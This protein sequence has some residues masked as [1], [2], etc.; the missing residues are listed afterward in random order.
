MGALRSSYEPNLVISNPVQIN[1]KFYCFP[2][3]LF[4]VVE[5]FSCLLIIL[6]NLVNNSW[7]STQGY[8]TA[9]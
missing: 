6:L 4:F 1:F 5:K 3:I 9:K 8:Y 2:H 7:S